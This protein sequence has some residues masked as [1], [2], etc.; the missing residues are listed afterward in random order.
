MQTYDHPAFV[1]EMAAKEARWKAFTEATAELNVRIRV[2][3]YPTYYRSV[4]YPRE[5]DTTRPLETKFFDL[6]R[7]DCVEFPHL[8]SGPCLFPQIERTLRARGAFS[9]LPNTGSSYGIASEDAVVY[10][11]DLDL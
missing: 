3:Y 7:K 9:Y 5:L 10:P 2:T 4:V 1:A 11:S 6:K 8:P